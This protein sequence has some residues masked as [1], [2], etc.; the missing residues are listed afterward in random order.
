MRIA[1]CASTL[2]SEVSWRNAGISRFG[3]RL[4]DALTRRRTG[5]S[6]EVYT[7]GVFQPPAEWGDRQNLR[8]ERVAPTGHGK[9]EAWDNFGARRFARPERCDVWLS[10]HHAIPYRSRVPTVITI[11]DMIPIAHPEYH[12]WKQSL[13]LRF[14]LISG[15]RRA[16]RILTN[17]DATKADIVKLARVPASKVLV[18]PL[19]PGS[20]PRDPRLEGLGACADPVP[21][22][23][24]ARYLFALGTLEPR[25]NFAG[26]VRAFAKV[27]SQS[28]LED[29]GLVVAG[30]RGWKEQSIFTEIERLG[31]AD[32]IA[33]L[34]YVPDGS[35]TALFAGSEA[36][37]L[38]SFEEGF[39]L[40]LLEAMI[41]GAPV[42][43]TGHGAT[44]ELAGDAGAFFNP[45]DPDDIARCIVEVLQAPAEYRAGMRLRGLER[46]RNF[47]WERSADIAFQAVE[48]ALRAA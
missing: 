29:V 22:I 28:G 10:T 36:F 11:H 25:K 4:I 1:V 34:G 13:F 18:M 24:F 17:S 14:S 9:K 37:I 45:F 23:P 15:A 30:G 5:D 48:E 6:F 19:G 27:S 40:P 16:T 33:F 41:A 3:S 47:S 31:M 32:K 21:Q 8:I 20:Q 26:L 39:G 35:L 38:P 12:D 46:S 43:T 7:Q 42:L 44:K 2:W